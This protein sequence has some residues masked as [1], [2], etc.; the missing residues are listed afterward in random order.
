MRSSAARLRSRPTA[1]PAATGSSLA[2]TILLPVAI[3]CS[4]WL[5]LACLA[6]ISDTD[7]LN[8]MLAEMR[9]LIGGRLP[10]WSGTCCRRWKSAAR[11]P[12]RPAAGAACRP[13]PRPG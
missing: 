11:R 8:I 10:G 2:L 4:R 7:G 9:L 13:L 3:C 12:G 5:S 6:I 1:A